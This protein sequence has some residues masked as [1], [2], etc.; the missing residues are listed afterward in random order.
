MKKLLLISLLIGASPLAKASCV[1]LS[2]TYRFS[3]TNGE[4]V[5]TTIKQSDCTHITTQ[6]QGEPS[7]PIIFDGIP[8][9]VED[10]ETIVGTTDAKGAVFTLTAEKGA[11]SFDFDGQIFL[12]QKTT[13]KME[14]VSPNRMR[15]TIQG[16]D[17]AGNVI[18]DQSM[19]GIR[20]H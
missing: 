20:I 5:D 8:R 13:L 9:I 18:V 14:L 15:F 4:T 10:G 11:Q 12:A 19:D 1:N 2:G 6:N 7:V 16:F 3:L 17:T